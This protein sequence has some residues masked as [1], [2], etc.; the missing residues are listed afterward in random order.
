MEQIKLFEQ[1]LI[2][3]G[4][5]T[6]QVVFLQRDRIKVAAGSEEEVDVF[7]EREVNTEKFRSGL[8]F[9]S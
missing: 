5:L 7:S 9:Q 8:T 4:I 3:K 2:E 1:Y 6:E